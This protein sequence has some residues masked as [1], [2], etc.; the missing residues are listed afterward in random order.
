MRWFFA[1]HYRQEQAVLSRE[2]EL[3][4]RVDRTFAEA[5]QV[6]KMVPEGETELRRS[7]KLVNIFKQTK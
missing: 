3:W 5:E 6:F 2:D 1:R 4:R 7:G